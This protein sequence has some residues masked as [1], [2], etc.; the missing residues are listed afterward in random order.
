MSDFITMVNRIAAEL[1]RSNISA[2]IR[3]AVNDAISEEARTPYYFNELAGPTAATF[4]TVIGQEYYPDLNFVHVESMYFLLGPT[5]FEIHP[6][7]KRAADANAT[8]GPTSGLPEFFSREAER[9]RIWPLPSVVT[10][11]FVE[12]H[13]RL[14]P[15]PMTANEDT[16]AW[17][18]TAER[19]IRNRA[20]SILCYD[21]IRDSKEGDY[22]A[23]L[24]A[25]ESARLIVETSKRVST[26]SVEPTSW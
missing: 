25:T 4:S 23:A 24:A 14:S 15:W 19:L 5:R 21:V 16:N 11:I 13:G 17:M 6:W 10:T 18:T 2:E 7:G 26:D 20:K 1:R 8:G 22:Y 12:G 3:A 9:F